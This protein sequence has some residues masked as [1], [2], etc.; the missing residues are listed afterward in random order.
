MKPKL[1]AILLLIAALF[2]MLAGCSIF[3]GADV[4]DGS[5]SGESFSA[6]YIDNYYV[7]KHTP[8]CLAGE[9]E[10]YK[11]DSSDSKIILLG[12]HYYRGGFAFSSRVGEYGEVE[13]PLE[14]LYKNVSFVIG[15]NH[16]ILDN[17]DGGVT[18]TAVGQ[19][20]DETAAVQ[21]LLDGRIVDE[22]RVSAY[23]AGRCFTYPVDGAQNFAF[24]IV[25]E[26]GGYGSVDS[27]VVAE[28]TV[29]E[30]DAAITGYTPAEP[31]FDAVQLVRELK[32]YLIPYSSGADYFP[33]GDDPEDRAGMLLGGIEYENVILTSI[34]A[35]LLGTDGEEIYF[36]LEGLYTNLTFT[37][38]AADRTELGEDKA[39]LSVYADG[40]IIYEGT[41]AA[42]E[43][44]KKI[45]L[46]VSG[47]RQL[48]FAW[49]G[50]GSEGGIYGIGD[51]YVASNPQA[52]S[53]VE[54]SV[55]EL[56]D[57]AVKMVSELGVFSHFSAADQAVFDG[58]PK[59]GSFLM[60]GREYSEG[61][62][63][64]SQNGLIGAKSASASFVLGGK[65]GSVTFLA[66]HIPNGGACRDEQVEIY[67][68]GV[69]IKT[70]EV[71]YGA[72]PKKY[73]LDVKGCNYLE[74]VS[75]AVTSSGGYSP[76]VGLARL[77]AYPGAV[78]EDLFEP[79][80][81]PEYPKF[82][83][84]IDL[85]GFYEVRNPDSERFIGAVGAEGYYDGENNKGAFRIDEKLIE[86]GVILRTSVNLKPNIEEAIGSGY[87]GTDITERDL[88]VIEMSNDGA[89][90]KSA[91][92]MANISGGGYT[93]VSFT[94]AFHSKNLASGAEDSTNLIIA[95][96][97]KCLA[98][99]LLTAEMKPQRLTL[100][101]EDCERLTFW[102]DCSEKSGASH[103]YAIY[104]I[105]LNK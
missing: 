71:E 65:Y 87:I 76:A 97:E 53:R 67:A 60:G 39:R 24:R 4:T 35:G 82:C 55:G 80:L 28:L 91:F 5:T 64:L 26:S 90:H 11:Y 63:L 81:T 70:F 40:D 61:I 96:D 54:Y 78:G 88:A 41:F 1:T 92:A 50:N 25:N 45:D 94:V 17:A 42:N 69:L 15:G 79:S 62:V 10:I 9:M 13:L 95:A 38:G 83:S 102:L 18:F 30:G 84:L 37:A 2:P 73:T 98:D 27:I 46:D 89:A 103:Y 58:S 57:R 77:S 44:Q 29:W 99:L 56:P 33:K 66:G 100:A 75:E 20:S 31:P 23:D 32:P 47:C 86:K 105:I 19:D 3:H 34:P 93:S 85:F 52:L 49:S 43:L 101:I 7:N 104:D 22:I 36:N 68:D 8:I 6:P 21:F 51:I 14:G 48:C 74:F 16:R 12:G 72:L 59:G